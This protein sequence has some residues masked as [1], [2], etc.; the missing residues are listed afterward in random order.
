M[1]F[2]DIQKATETIVKI[3]VKGSL[4]YGIGMVLFMYGFTI[5]NTVPGIILTVL[6]II[7]LIIFLVFNYF[8]YICT[9]L[10]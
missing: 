9:I 4:S 3:D 7:I 1:K 10:K 8:L 5:L 6:G 2:E